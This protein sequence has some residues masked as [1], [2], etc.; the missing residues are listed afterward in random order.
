[1]GPNYG[2]GE[3]SAQDSPF[4]GDNKCWS[5]TGRDSYHI[6]EEAGK[7]TLTN[8]KGHLFTI[9]ELEVWSIKEIEQ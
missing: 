2:G 1:M 5:G 3:L 8:K 6:P 9:T 7:N 4:N